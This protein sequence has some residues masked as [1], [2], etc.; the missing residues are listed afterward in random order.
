VVDGLAP[1][2]RVRRGFVV[3]DGYA[4]TELSWSGSDATQLDLPVHADG[5]IAG[6][7]AWVPGEPAP[8]GVALGAEDGWGFVEGAER[9]AGSTFAGAV[10]LRAERDGQAADVWL[11]APHDAE[12]WRAQAPGPP[13]AG[14][15]RFH[16]VRAR[17][18]AGRVVIVWS[19]A[20]AVAGVEERDGA[21]H[22]ALGDGTRHEHGRSA[23]GWRN[24]LFA[25]AAH[26]SI[27]LAGRVEPAA[28]PHDAAAAPSERDPDPPRR[29]PHGPRDALRFL[30]GEGDYRRSEATWAEAGSPRAELRVWQEGGCLWLALRVAHSALAFAPART[31]N[32][33]DNEHPDVNGDGAQ[34]YLRLPDGR[35]AAWVLVPEPG[36]ERVRVSP[37]SERTANLPLAASWTPL[38][39][40]SYEIRCAV[41]VSALG[42]R[43]GAGVG[44]ALAV[45]ESAPG[46]ERR[47]GQLVLGGGRGEFVYLRGDRHP[48]SRF[49]PLAIDDV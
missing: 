11:L 21:V 10:C 31:E 45:N 48:D 9:A 39:P 23:D 33:L 49:I 44:L 6:I 42:V 2:L 14:T 27:D 25:G 41:P 47:R 8:A 32:P 20:G 35:L 28:L 37:A 43:A 18:A 17:G 5:E 7:A 1:G 30:L 40:D 3:L 16:L 46:R 12:L 38:A 22:V 36:G 19:W 26:S 13:G 4:V 15:R 34:L 24:R 29:V